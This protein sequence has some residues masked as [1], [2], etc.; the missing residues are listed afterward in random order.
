MKVILIVIL[1]AISINLKAQAVTDSVIKYRR[2]LASCVKLHN[3]TKDSAQ[4]VRSFNAAEF[5]RI[6]Y[7]SFLE[8]ESDSVAADIKKKLKLK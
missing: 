8:Q 1:T 3:N 4:Y 7:D 5:W 2:L 6:K